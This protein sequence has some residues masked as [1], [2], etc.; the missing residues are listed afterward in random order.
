ME[1]KK[2]TFVGDGWNGKYDIKL[3]LKLSSLV[4]M[5]TDQWGNI[6][7]VLKE[8][9]T[10]SEKSKSTHF[11]AVDDWYYEHPKTD[12]KKDGLPF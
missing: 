8:R 11:V 9:K 6:H 2:Y 10:P 3:S 12:D 4:G 7:L 1:S 5:D